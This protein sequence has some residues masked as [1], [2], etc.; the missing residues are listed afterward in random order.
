VNLSFDLLFYFSLYHIIIILLPLLESDQSGKQLH[1]LATQALIV[2][3][4]DYKYALK[5]ARRS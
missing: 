3:A 4:C 2:V 5:K 1:H